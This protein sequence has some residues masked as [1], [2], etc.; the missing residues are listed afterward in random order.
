MCSP[1]ALAT[2]LQLEKIDHRDTEAQTDA[3][4]DAKGLT[5]DYTD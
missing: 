1:S 4:M 2:L 5:T 3:D